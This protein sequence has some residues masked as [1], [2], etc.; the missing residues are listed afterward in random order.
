MGLSI[1]ILTQYDD[2][3]RLFRKPMV[4]ISPNPFTDVI[5]INIGL[6][7]G[8]WNIYSSDG[9]IHYSRRLTTGEYQ[10]NISM[11]DFP[12]AL[13]YVVFVTKDRVESHSCLKL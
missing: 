1:E 4:T 7:T 9:T 11:K 8:V 2:T 10:I 13:Y 12:S 6:S 3:L 5:H